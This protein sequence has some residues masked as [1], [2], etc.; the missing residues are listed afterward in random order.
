MQN[1]QK[2]DLYL[3]QVVAKVQIDVVGHEYTHAVIQTTSNLKYEGQSG[4]LNEHLADVFGIIVNNLH[5]KS[6]SNPYLIGATVLAGEY[7]KKAHALRDMMDP[8]KGLSKQPGHMNDL[9]T[10][11]FAKFGEGCKSTRENDNCGVH[12]LS[13]IP[14]KMSALVMSAIGIQESAELFY[15]VMTKRLTENSQFADYRSAL[16]EECKTQ[17]SDTFTIVDEALKAVG[18]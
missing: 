16:M 7:A 6:L 15:N 13:G 4:A 8:G 2:Q 17:S 1:G 18:I 9:K 14:N 10:E 12:V 3:E 11:R 5:N